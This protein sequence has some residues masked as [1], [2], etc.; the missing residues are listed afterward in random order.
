MDFRPE[1]LQRFFKGNYSRKDYLWV[2]SIFADPCQ[3]KRLRESLENHWLDFEDSDSEHIDVNY[4]LQRIHQRIKSEELRT[5]K[6]RKLIFW[7]KI[8]AIFIFQ[9]IITVLAIYFL[10]QNQQEKNFLA[11]ELS[12]AEIQCPPG[13]RIKF[14]LPDGSTGFLNSGSSLKYP[15]QFT[16]SRKVWLSGEA[17]FDVAHDAEH[18]FVVRANKL[19]VEVLGTQFD[20]IAY[21]D[22]DS[23]EIVLNRG[24]VKVLAGNGSTL[25]VLKPNQRLVLDVK[26]MT[27]RKEITEASQY[28]GWTKG[29]LVLRNEPMERVVKRLSRWYNVDIAIKD[30][31][32]REYSFRA[33]FIDEPLDE[34]LKILSKTTPMTY[35]IIEREKSADGIY[36][37]KKVE[38]YFD[39]KRKHAF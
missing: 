29:M 14:N 12:Y 13:A 28:L 3:E 37:K 25:S 26:K 23:E 15:V 22:D 34:V 18:P 8:A 32:L 16:S 5:R 24:A 27:Y 35:R 36:I 4:L 9:L 31:R 20:V 7:R 21:N 2:K 11:Q 17:W 10:K 30:K 19:N 6:I 39:Q 38:L 1:I 33:T